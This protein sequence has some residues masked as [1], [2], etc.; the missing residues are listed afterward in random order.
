MESLSPG[1]NVSP[2]FLEMYRTGKLVPVSRMNDGF[3]RP[4][5]PEQI[6]YSY[7]QA[8]LV[9]DL[10]VRDWG[11]KSITALLGEYR[12]GRTTEEAFQKVVGMDM[13]AFDRRFDAYMR[14]RFGGALAALA[15][16]GPEYPAGM[17]PAELASRADSLPGSYRAQL[18]AGAALVKAGRLPAAIRVLE[19]AHALFPLNGDDNSPAAMLATLYLGGRDTA[20][21][22][23]MLKV[24]AMADESAYAVNRELAVLLLSARDTIGAMAAMER[25]LF[26]NP[27]PVELHSGLAALAAARGDHPRHVRERE[28]LVALDPVDKAEVQYQLAIA[29][30][31][32]G[33]LLKAKRAV[34]RALE[35]APNF[36]R[37]QDL[38]L[39][40][41][42][43]RK[44]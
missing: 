39:A 35:D 15:Q 19:R 23:A 44:P 37:A 7:Y 3:M 38:L 32:A 34:L 33:D 6:G 41:V 4:T 29:Y 5:Y 27:F 28:A 8:S 43:G 12:A 30:R 1:A 10:I 13:K 16:P 21:A 11:E 22:I 24:V 9:C 42:D 25:A 2:G 36:E 40:I 31:D 18:L 17:G 26:I 14:E 20:K